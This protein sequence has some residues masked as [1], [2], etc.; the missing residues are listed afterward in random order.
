M[1]I[2]D[3]F[4]GSGTINA[5]AAIMGF[6]TVGSDLNPDF[7]AGAK[8]NFQFLSEKF[9]YDP[10]VGEFLVQDATK[11]PFETHRG[12]VVT[13]GWLG[14]NFHRRPTDT[15]IRKNAATVLMV[16]EK[17]FRNLN[18]QNPD[19]IKTLA[20]CLPYWQAGQQNVSIAKK[21]FAKISAF[22]YHPRALFGGNTTYVYSRP[23]AFVAREICVVERK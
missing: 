4:C 10:E 8:K 22:G 13:E 14:Q 15:Q 7:L 12:V 20:F 17:F 6:S 18:K 1:K 3:P 19:Q 2:I 9:R 16:W 23:G 21:L 5:E 11:F